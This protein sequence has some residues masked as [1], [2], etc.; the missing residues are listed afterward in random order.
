MFI[1]YGKQD[2]TEQDVEEIINILKSDYLT[3]NNVLEPN[4]K[5]NP[6]RNDLENAHLLL[7]LQRQPFNKR[8]VAN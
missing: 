3:Q 2:V 1:P 4:T 7:H 8:L 5:L 6:L